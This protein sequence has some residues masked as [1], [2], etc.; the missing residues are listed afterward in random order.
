MLPMRA[1]R[2]FALA[3]VILNGSGNFFQLA[4]AL[5]RGDVVIQLDLD[6]RSDEMHAP[7]LFSPRQAALALR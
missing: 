1:C 4:S 5:S 7:P 2:A 6:D 3:L